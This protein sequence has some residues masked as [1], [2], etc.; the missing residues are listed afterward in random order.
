MSQWDDR[1]YV[2]NVLI[3]VKKNDHKYKKLIDK[4]QDAIIVQV[5]YYCEICESI[6]HH[7]VKD[8]PRNLKNVKHKWCV[9]C[10]E[11]THSMLECQRNG[12]NKPNYQIIYH[13]QDADQ[14][15]AQEGGRGDDIYQRRGGYRG[16]GGWYGS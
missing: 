12:I 6:M 7:I 11:P 3:R 5:K 9:I 8:Y 16:Q 1:T 14:N 13:A 4:H 10:E 2:Y 15:Q